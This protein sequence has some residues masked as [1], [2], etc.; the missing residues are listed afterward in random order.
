MSHYLIIFITSFAIYTVFIIRTLNKAIKA[1]RKTVRNEDLAAIYDPFARKDIA[2]W[3]LFEIY[4]CG[5]FLLPLRLLIS[6]ICGLT[7]TVI[8]KLLMWGVDYQKEFSTFRRTMVRSLTSI[9][10]RIILYCAG[11]YN[12]KIEK[13][14]LSNVDPTYPRTQVLLNQ[15]CR[16]PIIV[17]NHISWVDIFAHMIYSESPSFLAKKDVANYPIVGVIAKSMQGL[18]VERELRTNKDFIIDLIKSRVNQIKQG[19]QIPQVLIFPE[20]T[21]TNG[22]YLISF[23]KGAFLPLAPIKIKCLK[24]NNPRFNPSLD[25]LGAGIT[26]LL[27]FC[28]FSNSLTIYEYDNFYPDYLNLKDE[29]D[30]QIYANK[31]KDIMLKTLN[32]KSS[33]LGFA[34]KNTYINTVRGKTPQ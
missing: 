22:E 32:C 1:A 19:S 3:N 26:F 16:A 13:R 21:T 23:K 25:V 7:C 28:Q 5:I 30:W 10:P 31:V 2:N 27:T 24:Y 12:I 6:L 20:G 14:L 4:F 8:C 18:F 17:S 11:F 34:E 15:N 33:E 9:F 29:N